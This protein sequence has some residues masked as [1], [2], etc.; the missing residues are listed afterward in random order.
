MQ[1]S[2]LIAV[3]FAFLA[4]YPF[5]PSIASGQTLYFESFDSG[6]ASF[7]SV[8]TD[9][10]PGTTNASSGDLVMSN[11]PIGF[12]TAPTGIAEVQNLSQTSVRTQISFSGD[13]MESGGVAIFTNSDPSLGR[14]TYYQGGINPTTNDLYIGWNEGFASTTFDAVKSGFDFLGG[15]EITLQFDVIGNQLSLWAWRPDEPMP[16]IP[17][18]QYID[19]EIMLPPGTPGLLFDGGGSSQ[20]SATYRYFEVAADSIPPDPHSLFDNFDDG[21]IRDASPFSWTSNWGGGLSTAVSGLTL[22]GSGS[23]AASPT[24][25]SDEG[26]TIET[27]TSVPEDAT[28][29]GVG[30]IFGADDNVWLGFQP[31]GVLA[32]GTPGIQRAVMSTGLDPA[33]VMLRFETENDVLAGW[34]WEPGT[35]RP[36]EP[37]V[38]FDLNELGPEFNTSRPGTPGLWMEGASAGAL[39]TFDFFRATPLSAELLGD[40]DADGVLAASDIDLLSQAIREGAGDLRF[41]LNG[42]GTV[43]LQDHRFWVNDQNS[44]NTFF[45]DSN[46]DGEFNSSDLVTVFEAGEYEDDVSSNSSWTTGDW[47]GNGDFDS[48]DLVVAFQHGGYEL[49]PRSEVASVPEPSSA[50]MLAL[51][52]VALLRRRSDSR[53]ALAR[54]SKRDRTCPYATQIRT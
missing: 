24:G 9:V 18:L 14:I 10:S 32:I 6:N 17:Q 40:F 3:L 38:L 48:S 45:G 21:N 7:R 44:A 36:S 39:A 46:L 51:V 54:A 19:R 37:M 29:T 8:W 28:W 35:R 26:W 16:S 41:D 31:D 52:F 34:A 2:Q 20:T 11:S 43:D 4:P 1:R 12:V 13:P 15:E 33:D 47:D 23:R 53:A 30:V 50:S 49:G 25:V 27:R 42:D 22:R 5:P